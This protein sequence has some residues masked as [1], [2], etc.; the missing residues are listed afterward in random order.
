[1]SFTL[2]DWDI[3][4]GGRVLIA[5]SSCKQGAKEEPFV[6]DLPEIQ[7]PVKCG[8]VLLSITGNRVLRQATLFWNMSVYIQAA[9]RWQLESGAQH[10]GRSTS[11]IRTTILERLT[12]LHCCVKYIWRGA[13][14]SL[15]HF[16]PSFQWR[17]TVLMHLYN[18]SLTRLINLEIC[19]C[20]VIKELVVFSLG[21]MFLNN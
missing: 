18:Y 13:K 21:R 6:P 14:Q 15:M 19:Y 17:Q 20:T 11:A 5:M 10:K 12:V 1:M 4:V 9:A 8:C 3:W 16:I 2:L 7:L